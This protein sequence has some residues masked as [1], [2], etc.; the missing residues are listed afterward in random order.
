MHVINTPNTSSNSSLFYDSLNQKK[1]ANT[2]LINMNLKQDKPRNTRIQKGQKKIGENEITY[3][4]YT[5]LRNWQRLNTTKNYN[6]IK[7]EFW[8]K[9]IDWTRLRSKQ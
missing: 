8:T 9:R 2:E 1:P 3:K 7:T 4:I 6:A 5:A